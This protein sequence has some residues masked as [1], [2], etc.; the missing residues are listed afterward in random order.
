MQVSSRGRAL[1][2]S[3]KQRLADDDSY[4]EQ[5]SS[6]EERA[7]VVGM[8]RAVLNVKRGKR[9]QILCEVAWVSDPRRLVFCRA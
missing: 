4:S 8:V 2:T 7:E 9:R 1:R 3:E 5:E 6:E